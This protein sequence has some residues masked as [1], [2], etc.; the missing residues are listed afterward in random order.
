MIKSNVFI[1][2]LALLSSTCR[3]TCSENVPP[4]PY[5]QLLFG[6]GAS[7][8]GWGETLERVHTVDV[9]FRHCR[10]FFRKDEGLIRGIH[11]FWIEVPVSI[12]LSDSDSNDS[13]DIGFFG[14]NFLFAW[15]FPEIPAGE[16][17]F[18]IGGGP[19]YVAADIDGVGSDLCGN[20][21]AGGGIRFEINRQPVNVE[22]RL[23]H[24]SNLGM[25]EPNVPLNSTKL[26]FGFTL[27]F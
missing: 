21:Q 24:I 6:W 25:A 4:D 19:V 17:Y 9:L 11:E 12:L 1:A 15:I 2:A 20:Y 5:N 22:A 10:H 18:M 16:P 13:K 26:F 8:P 3:N 23:H 27:P 14:A 7:H